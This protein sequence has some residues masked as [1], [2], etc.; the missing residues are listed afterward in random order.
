MPARQPTVSPLIT[1]EHAGKAVPGEWQHLFEGRQSLLDSHRGY[2]RGSLDVG[3]ALAA[4]LSAPL[5]AGTVTRLLVDLNRS[6]GHPRHFSELTRRLPAADKDR[7]D[8]EFWWPH[9]SRYRE[10][11]E[12][13]PGQIVHIACHSFVP[14]LDGKFRTA[15]IGLLYDPK[16]RREASWCGRLADAIERRLPAVRARMNYPYRGTSNGMGQQHRPLFNDQRLITMELEV[17]Q[18]LCEC[19]GWSGVVSGLVDA[20]G[21][22]LHKE[23]KK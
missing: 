11:L 23:S 2:D 5:L 16:R 14:V 19:D 1:C 21:E 9:W 3:Q 7:V 18:R 12:H 17:N 13:L 8:A 22:T 20:V 15:D 4:S 6:R 10:Y